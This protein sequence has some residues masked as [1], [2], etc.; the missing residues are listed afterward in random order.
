MS[1]M[2]G[3]LKSKFRCAVEK[4][5]DDE[6]QSYLDQNADTLTKRQKKI[7]ENEQF[8]RKRMGCRLPDK[9]DPRPYRPWMDL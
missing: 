3:W 9:H 5:G 8:G 7:I 2:C 1:W 4:M 6:L